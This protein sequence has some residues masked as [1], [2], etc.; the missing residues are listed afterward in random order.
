M[1]EWPHAIKAQT[2]IR[3]MA[4]ERT[5]HHRSNIACFSWAQCLYIGLSL[6]LTHTRACTTTIRG[7]IRVLSVDVFSPHL[8]HTWV[9]WRPFVTDEPPRRHAQQ[10]EIHLMHVWHDSPVWW[11]LRVFRQHDC[12]FCSRERKDSRVF[13]IFT[14]IQLIHLNLMYC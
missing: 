11:R 13:S 7:A 4:T 10:G 5:L 3:H 8:C 12:S 2:A 1:F 6:S 14:H 9:S